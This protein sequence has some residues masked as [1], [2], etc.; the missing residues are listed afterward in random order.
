M[1]SSTKWL[2]VL[3]VLILLYLGWRYLWPGGS[4]ASDPRKAE[5]PALLLDRVWIDSKPDKYTDYVHAALLLDDIPMGLFQ[6]A[7]AYH[8]V[9]ELFEF[10]RAGAEVRVHFP[11]SDTTKKFTYQV[12]RC[13]DLPP[14][15]LCLT[16]SKHPWGGPKRY[17]GLRETEDERRVLGDLR[18]RLE[19]EVAGARGRSSAG[20]GR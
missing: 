4:A 8:V 11:Q 3:I 14:F 10:K 12:T 19:A 9:L 18:T 6:K 20:A 5:D 2:V 16:L 17:Y 7:S 1:K 15:D 13:D